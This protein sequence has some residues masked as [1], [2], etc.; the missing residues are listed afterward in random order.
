MYTAL[1]T[2][3]IEFMVV[4]TNTESNNYMLVVKKKGIE[5]KIFT[6]DNFVIDDKHKR[7][8]YLYEFQHG[9]GTY[10]FELYSNYKDN[11]TYELAARDTIIK[12]DLETSL[13]SKKKVYTTA[14]NMFCNLIDIPKK[15]QGTVTLYSRTS[16]SIEV[17]TKI[18]IINLPLPF[19]SSVS[20][21]KFNINVANGVNRVMSEYTDDVLG[22]IVKK[23]G[24]I[25]KI[26]SVSWLHIKGKI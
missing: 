1:S 21:V 12:V 19:N 9:T 22:K 18:G 16:N 20:T 15:Y 3:P 5:D 14:I 2:L 17:G 7:I 23:V 24:T 11:L 4:T 10:T 25:V 26:D 8:T 13:F 6:H